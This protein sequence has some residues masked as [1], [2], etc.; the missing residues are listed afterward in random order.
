MAADV[1]AAAADGTAAPADAAP[2][3][4]DGDDLDRMRQIID[5]SVPSRLLLLRLWLVVRSMLVIF[6]A[7]TEL[8]CTARYAEVVKDLWPSIRPM[9]L[10]PK[11]LQSGVMA[12]PHADVFAPRA[13]R[14]VE[15]APREPHADVCAAR[16][17]RADASA[18]REPHVVVCAARAARAD[19]SAPREPQADV[20]AARAPPCVSR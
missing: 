11:Q 2:G 12:E 17:A 19:A 7:L 13:A 14:A 4:A 20:C 8:L 18:P 16:A 10:S 1:E 3:A 6:G 5:A 9:L 15:C